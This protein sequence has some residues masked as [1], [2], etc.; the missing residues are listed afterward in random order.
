M[1]LERQA[2]EKGKVV[3]RRRVTARRA[4]RADGGG[5]GG[6]AAPLGGGGLRFGRGGSLRR[7]CRKTACLRKGI[8]CAKR[9]PVCEY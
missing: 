1:V 2:T 6:R 8:E 7:L 4:P 3:A 5:G 9:A